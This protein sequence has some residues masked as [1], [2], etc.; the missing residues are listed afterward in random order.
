MSLRK[1][2]RDVADKPTAVRAYVKKKIKE[3]RGWALKYA[4]TWKS[5]IMSPVVLACMPGDSNLDARAFTAANVVIYTGILYAIA[6]LRDDPLRPPGASILL[7]EGGYFAMS[8]AFVILWLA[9]AVWIAKLFRREEQKDIAVPFGPLQCGALYTLSGPGLV[10][11]VVGSLIALV[12]TWMLGVLAKAYFS[13]N[14]VVTLLLVPIIVI[15]A[16]AIVPAVMCAKVFRRFY[17]VGWFRGYILPVLIYAVLVASFV[18]GTSYTTPS[19]FSP[20]EKTALRRTI[21]LAEAESYSQYAVGHWADSFS[22]VPDINV[23]MAS[24]HLSNFDTSV[25]LAAEEARH[26]SSEMDGYSYQIQIKGSTCYI[27]ARPLV[28][29]KVT[30]RSFAAECP[31]TPGAS[32]EI[33]SEDAKGGNATLTSGRVVQYSADYLLPFVNAAARTEAHIETVLPAPTY[34]LGMTQLPWKGCLDGSVQISWTTDVPSSTTVLYGPSHTQMTHRLEG[35]S[36][37]HH[38]VNI[39]A[40]DVSSG[41]LQAYRTESKTA[42]RRSESQDYRIGH[43]SR[44]TSDCRAGQLSTPRLPKLF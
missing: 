22:T 21:V 17:K 43:L 12:L 42:N 20:A 32:P 18:W 10:I 33:V 2:Q 9:C 24:V 13:V 26:M 11:S 38:D 5:A 28:P 4:K 39:P 15:F 25:L 19:A 8:T 16:A 30:R 31:T 37:T 7:S 23:S 36:G 41:Q 34:G 1:T 14:V 6:Y 3:Y 27:W 40:T 44:F 29:N 35:K